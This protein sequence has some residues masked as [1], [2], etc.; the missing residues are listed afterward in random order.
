MKKHAFIF[1]CFRSQIEDLFKISP[2][3]FII[4][5]LAVHLSPQKIKKKKKQMRSVN[6]PL[7]VS[8]PST[9][10][11]SRG[12]TTKT[13]ALPPGFVAFSGLSIF[14][15]GATKASQMRLEQRV[16]EEMEKC[17]Q[18][19]IDTSDLF[20]D[21]DLPG[22][23]YPFGDAEGMDWVPD[24]W[25]PPKKGDPKFLPTRMLGQLTM[26]NQLYD[27]TIKAQEQGVDVSDVLVPFV[28]EDGN[29]CDSKYDSNQKRYIE[30]RKRLGM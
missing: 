26:R 10:K 30:I 3:S 16:S 28:D 21:F 20:Y 9:S 5:R 18:N 2:P 1:F 23:A 24:D 13:S 27:V 19:G 8:K 25:K 14:L 15:V 12:A 22:D 11:A 17:N 29:A 6:A 7:A 4:T